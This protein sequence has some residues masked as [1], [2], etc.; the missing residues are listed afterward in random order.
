MKNPS[1]LKKVT[2]WVAVPALVLFAMSCEHLLEQVTTFDVTVEETIFEGETATGTESSLEIAN[3]QVL[4]GNGGSVAKKM[5]FSIF[6]VIPSD[7]LLFS[8]LYE[9]DLL[10]IQGS[11]ENLDANPVEFSVYF[12][13]SDGLS[14]P[15]HQGIHVLTETLGGYETKQIDIV[16]TGL[17][18][19]F[20]HFQQSGIIYVYLVGTESETV[21]ILVHNLNF[22][23]PAAARL[24]MTLDPDEY[25]EYLDQVDDITEMQI[26]GSAVNHGNHPVNF[27]LSI[28]SGT[29][30]WEE[31]YC[32]EGT[33]GSVLQF[34]EWYNT[35]VE[36]EIEH[37]REVVEQ[38]IDGGELVFVQFFVWSEGDINLEI[39]SLVINADLLVD[40][41]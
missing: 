13:L 22:S 3:N 24:M 21:N 29:L 41:D 17:E 8:V 30:Y 27:L 35:F 31:H 32:P 7:A 33:N 28:S 11:V 19:F 18:D 14:D 23:M 16:L 25:E 2:C 39:V 37:L 26:S 9:K 5:D 40:V 12:G 36:N 34:A 15:E 4:T 6:I 38:F 1:S 10:T 20:D